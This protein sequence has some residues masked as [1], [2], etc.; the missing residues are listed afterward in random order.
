MNGVL[1]VGERDGGHK[2]RYAV[3][4]T[5]LDPGDD[6]ARELYSTSQYRDLVVI[7]GGSGDIP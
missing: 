5:K 3:F 7:E 6:G 1:W 4:R 2:V